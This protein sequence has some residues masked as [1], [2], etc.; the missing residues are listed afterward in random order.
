[1]ERSV[2]EEIATDCA[3]F[4]VKKYSTQSPKNKKRSAPV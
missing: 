4:F 3:L 2:P 1:M